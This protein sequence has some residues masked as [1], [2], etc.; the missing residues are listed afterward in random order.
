MIRQRRCVRFFLLNISSLLPLRC[1]RVEMLYIRVTIIDEPSPMVRRILFMRFSDV[2]S[3]TTMLIRQGAEFVCV[4]VNSTT[5]Q[6]AG[7]AI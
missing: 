7:F 5:K 1:R 2:I 3:S 6:N 4:P